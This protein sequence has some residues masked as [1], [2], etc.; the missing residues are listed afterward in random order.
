VKYIRVYSDQAGDSHFG[1]VEVD[2]KPIDVAPPAPPVNVAAVIES[3]RMMLMS[4]PQGWYGDWPHD[5]SS[6]FS[7]LESLSFVS[8]T[9]ELA[10]SL[11][12]RSSL[13]KIS[14]A[15]AI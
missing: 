11:L 9:A 13:W 1:E 5:D 7:Y 14:Q 12:E 6:T 10:P 15:K 4:F 2:L 8:A 3:E